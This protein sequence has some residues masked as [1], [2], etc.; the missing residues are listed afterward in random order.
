MNP[1]Y[2]HSRWAA[3]DQEVLIQGRVPAGAAR[4]LP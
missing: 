3:K 1:N 2:T 4:R